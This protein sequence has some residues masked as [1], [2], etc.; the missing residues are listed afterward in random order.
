VGA[1]D[2]HHGSDLVSFI[3]SLQRI[4]ASSVEWLLPSHGPIFRKDD[5]LIDATIERLNRYLHM[6]DFGTCAQDWPL[7]DEW[8]KELAEGKFPES[9]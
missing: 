7:M 6:S 1:I 9:S 3:Q 4:R 2:A 5:Q 8:E